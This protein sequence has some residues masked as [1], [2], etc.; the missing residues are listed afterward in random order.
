MSV[1][2]DRLVAAEDL[3]A[4]ESYGFAGGEA[5][6]FS[7][8]CPGKEGANEDAVSAF[9]VGAA[10]GL[11][12]VADGMGGGAAG[13]RASRIALECLRDAAVAVEGEDSLR[14]S[15]LDVFEEANR[16]ILELGVG[17]A[18]TLC[19]AEI[20]GGGL[21]LYHVGD[22]GALVIGQ[23]GK[24]KLQT[25]AHSPVG[26]AV[27]SGLLDESEAL[28]HDERHIVSNMLGTTDMRIE[29]GS[30]LELAERDTVLLASDGLFDNLSLSEIVEGLR[31]GP[32][33]VLAARLVER[34]RT[35]M[36]EPKEGQP[37]KPDDLGFVL[38]RRR[39]ARDGVG[40]RRRE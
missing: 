35:R 37:S 7:A 5:V 38:F 10:R 40:R 27:E 14:A 30:R 9:G 12:A 32:L 34:C 15:V 31:S 8:R 13:E 17:A 4:P 33:E 1:S 23:R 29:V 25:I 19:V 22:S 26:Y 18:T 39:G 20:D 6:V 2:P 11:L 16:R 28:H 24:L 36:R 3:G 21:R